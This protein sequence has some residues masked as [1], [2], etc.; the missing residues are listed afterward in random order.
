MNVSYFKNMLLLVIGLLTITL[1]GSDQAAAQ[2]PSKSATQFNRINEVIERWTPDRHLFVKGDLGI[3]AMQL[4]GLE[5]WLDANAK[6]WVVVLMNNAIG[7]RYVAADGNSYAGM[8]AVEHALGK[9]LNNRTDFGTLT[10]PQ[11][12]ERDG[13]VF[14]LFLQ[15][16][17]FSYYA[18]D[19]QD[20]RNLGDGHWIGQLD[21]PAIRAMRSGGRI[22][23]AVKDTI[24]SIDQQ[25]ARVVSSEVANAER[26]KLELQRA[27]DAL[28]SSI[29][30]TRSMIDDVKIASAEYRKNNGSAA[31]TLAQ[32]PLDK[33][34]E[35]VASIETDPQPENVRE[36]QQRLARTDDSILAHLNGYAAA[37]GLAA[38]SK[39]FNAELKML[40]E[41]PAT[42]AVVSDARAA[43]A[44][45]EKLVASGDLGVEA[46]LSKVDAAIE[47]GQ[48]LVGLERA[49]AE[50]EQLVRRWVRMTVLIMLALVALTIAVVLWLFNRRR[51]AIMKK[52]LTTIAERES[53]VMQETEGID[54]LF[55]RNE[56]LLGSKEKIIERG[57]VGATR[58]ASEQA[59]N[60]V[61]DLFI[62]SKEVRRVLKEAKNLVEPVSPFSKVM[63]LFSGESYQQAVNLVTG[64]PLKF[65]RLNGLPFVLRERLANESKNSS[66]SNDLPDE[67]TMTFED[68]FQAF[69]QRGVDAEVMLNTVESCLTGIHETLT[70]AQADLQ[71]CVAQD[72]QLESESG[73]DNYFN[74]PDYLDAL[75]PAVEKDLAE[76]DKLSAFDA[77]GAMQNS[78]PPAQR[79][80]SEAIALGQ[81]LL[82]ARQKL[83]PQLHTQADK[84]GELRF[85]SH[86]ID[87]ELRGV[88]QRANALMK[89][90]VDHSIAQDTDTI[91][92]ELAALVV[93]AEEAATLGERIRR[94]LYP[95]GEALKQRIAAA[96][97]Q[98]APQLKL[99]ESQV[100]HEIDRDPD[101]HWSTAGKSLEAAGVSVALGQNAAAKAA[102][103]VMLAEV[104]QADGIIQASVAAV[105]SFAKDKQNAAVELNRLVSRVPQVKAGIEDLRRRYVSSTLEIRD[106]IV[107]GTQPPPLP[108]QQLP[109]QADAPEHVDRLLQMANSPLDK[110]ES[111][112]RL[113]ESEHTE[114][115]VLHA[116]AMLGDAA[117]QL[118]MAHE[119]LDR[120]ETYLSHVESQ[121]RENETEL[122]RVQGLLVTL[123]ANERD[124]L[125]TRE[126]LSAIASAGTAAAQLK[127]DLSS[128]SAAPNPFDIQ[129]SL[130]TLRQTI[131]SLESRCVSDRQANAEAA[132]AVAGA[133]RQHQ[134]AEQLVRQSQTDGIPDSQQTKAAN[135]RIALLYKSLVQIENQLREPHGDW[136]TVDQDASRLQADLSAATDTLSGELQSATQA[137]NLFQQASQ[138]VFQAEQWS[139]RYGIRVSGSP[140]VRELERARASL[141]QGNYNQVLEVARLAA[142]AALAA[143]QQ[144]EREVERRRMAEEAEAERRRRE[145][146]RRNTPSFGP[147]IVTGGSRSSGGL[148]GGSSLGGGSFGGGS[149]GGGGSS[150]GGGSSG[151]GFSRS[152]W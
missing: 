72:K 31:G 62:M 104:A 130:E 73:T 57:Y 140:G 76:A 126:T 66:A 74:L 46:E 125:V 3:G 16:R 37:Q 9:D 149:F 11:T 136:K 12:G 99:A 101:E 21:Q 103:E 8:D 108:K 50:R 68:V 96:R 132:R 13:A 116:A 35:E 81:V 120:T 83:F 90:A 89:S 138:S 63:N 129:A 92:N 51:A 110:V 131:A 93:R 45:A 117:T 47:E 71:K 107:P 124:P 22:L 95:E 19:A 15:E 69:K 88:S 135:D 48:H 115:K 100:L 152:G 38:Q 79:K 114:G 6:H 10:H 85:T 26:A 65:S 59:I 64:K 128:A 113:A 54:R 86:W 2:Q 106:R 75:I 97:K 105:N 118:A 14:V 5:S 28:R 42:A 78:L 91:K 84:L 87:A 4:D 123:A 30:H 17:K 40:A 102:I 25:L 142:A 33:W 94:E 41:T 24:T 141:Q 60:F 67:I 7:E 34:R 122:S 55:T 146:A 151:S 43:I 36:L 53:Q 137:L 23:D 18:S 98:L 111:V 44:A 70:A 139:G 145:A 143:I 119:Q 1:S 150:S 27:L 29:V 144:A 147:I 49:K 77:V 39:S 58:E 121:T 109:K 112:L 52:A 148:F 80:M 133:R 61:D 32:P 127:R 56:E 134:T 82:E 20:R